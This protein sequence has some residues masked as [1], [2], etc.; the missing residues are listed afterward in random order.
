MT[1]REWTEKYRPQSFD[2]MIGNEPVIKTGKRFARNQNFP[3][4][5]LSG[6]SGTGKTTFLRVLAYECFG[7]E[8]DLLE[9]NCSS[10]RGIDIMRDEVPN[11]AMTKSAYGVPFKILGLDEAEQLTTPAQKACKKISEDFVENCKFVLITNEEEGLIK[12]LTSRF[13]PL[14]FQRI[15]TLDI[16]KVL[17]DI[18]EEEEV[19]MTRKAL[20]KIALE[21]KGDL[22]Q[23]IE[24]LQSIAEG[25]D[26]VTEEEVDFYLANP[27]KDKIFLIVKSALKGYLV[28]SLEDAEKLMDT[29]TAR[30]FFTVVTDRF[31]NGWKYSTKKDQVLVDKDCKER[32]ARALGNINLYVPND[33]MSVYSFLAELSAE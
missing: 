1:Y 25:E 12:F 5:L 26:E 33:K 16:T 28:E 22:R 30:G 29:F 19:D 15:R 18:T 4:L 24:T 2:E 31:L 21:S 27:S 17:D 20:L 9:L 23:A 14:R 32:I 13:R 11:Y 6:G 7:D 3:R 8:A 10:D